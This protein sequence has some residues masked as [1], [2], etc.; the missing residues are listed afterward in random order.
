MIDNTDLMQEVA[1]RLF[2]IFKLMSLIRGD[3]EDALDIYATPYRIAKMWVNE[4]CINYPDFD[5]YED[6]YK[7]LEQTFTTFP[8]EPYYDSIVEVKDIPFSSICSH[9]FMP[10]IGKVNVYYA[11]FKKVAGLS[12]I[13]RVI[14]FFS[15]QPQLQEK[16][17]YDI[18][19]FLFNHLEPEF[20]YVE[21]EAE[22]TCVSVRGA[23]TPCK[24]VTRQGQYNP[25]VIGAFEKYNQFLK[26]VK[27]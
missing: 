25:N 10:F 5:G 8:N 24:T 1:D 6:R 20:V 19:S 13:P 2:E 16:L 7:E 18:A 21:I 4:L 22:H 14:K 15:K 26:E 11:P 27:K 23:E 17:T 3:K 12:K 9:H